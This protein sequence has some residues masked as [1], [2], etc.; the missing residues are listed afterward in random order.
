MMKISEQELQNMAPQIL[1]RK[2][3]KYL[4]DIMK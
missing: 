4:G 2:I 3:R 1:E